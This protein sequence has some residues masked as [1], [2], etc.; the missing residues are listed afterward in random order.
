MDKNDEEL[1]ESFTF[2]FPG[3]IKILALPIQFFLLL[4]PVCKVLPC[5]FAFLSYRLRKRG[6]NEKDNRD[7]GCSLGLGRK[8][9]FRGIQRREVQKH[10]LWMREAHR[11]PYFC[12]FKM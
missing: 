1:Y 9:T 8:K 12:C 4:C 2:L 3:L 5:N 11:S 6:I 7:T 10:L